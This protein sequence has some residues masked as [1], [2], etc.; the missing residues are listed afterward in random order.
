MDDPLNIFLGATGTSWVCITANAQ[1][2][3]RDTFGF[4]QVLDSSMEASVYSETQGYY[5]CSLYKLGVQGDSLEQTIKQA[6]T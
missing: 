5:I 6:S 3:G 4:S 2:M 1:W